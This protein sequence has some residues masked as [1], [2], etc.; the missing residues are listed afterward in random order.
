MPDLYSMYG[1]RG[2]ETRTCWLGGVALVTLLGCRRGVE[3]PALV[4]TGHVGDTGQA[5]PLLAT[6]DCLGD[7]MAVVCYRDADGDGFAPEDATAQ[8][9]C[10]TCPNGYSQRV[11]AEYADCDDENPA[12]YPGATEIC[13]DGVNA[14]CDEDSSDDEAGLTTWF[15]DCD[16]DG[17]GNPGRSEGADCDGP[18]GEPTCGDVELC[19]DG[20]AGWVANNQDTDDRGR[21]CGSLLEIDQDGDG[22]SPSQGDC[23]DDDDSLDPDLYTHGDDDLMI[24]VS[25]GGA[26]TSDPC[27]DLD[28]GMSCPTLDAAIAAAPDD[29][30]AIICLERGTYSL[31]DTL[32]LGTKE[33]VLAGQGSGLTTLLETGQVRVVT[34]AG[35]Q[36]SSTLLYGLTISG[37]AVQDGAGVYVEDSSPTLWRLTVKG[38][39]SEDKPVEKGGGLALIDSEAIVRD[40]QISSNWA[41]RGG[42]M[43]LADGT[44]SPAFDDVTVQG[45]NATDGGGVY[46]D[47]DGGSWS[48][49][50]LSVVSNRAGGSGGGLYILDATVSASAM[51]LSENVAVDDGG[52]L[53]MDDGAFN[54]TAGTS[55]SYIEQNSA[56]GHGGGLCAT[57]AELELSDALVQ[58]NTASQGAGLYATYGSLGLSGVRLIENAAT[59]DGGG[60]WLGHT[61]T[62]L[63]EVSIESNTSG[64][65]GGG[66]YFDGSGVSLIWRRTPISILVDGL[67]VG[68]L[69]RASGAF[70]TS[71]YRATTLTRSSPPPEADAAD[72]LL[73]GG[74]SVELIPH[75]CPWCYVIR[76]NSGLSATDSTFSANS[77]DDRGGALYAAGGQVVF[78]GNST[79]EENAASNGGALALTGST[80]ATGVLTTYKNTASASGGA[81]YLGEDAD[82]DISG[83]CFD[84]N[85]AGSGNGNVLATETNSYAMDNSDFYYGSSDVDRYDHVVYVVP[86]HGTLDV[87]DIKGSTRASCGS[88]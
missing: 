12:I 69:E 57:G 4:E 36:E 66:I 55:G 44:E 64:D 1:S 58:G 87:D 11:S 15:A 65:D 17:L 3:Q 23:W 14:D 27:N 40:V 50:G 54:V 81:L 59:D 68:K 41:L 74:L 73:V 7:D 31:T 24:F 77:A 43:Y 80:T 18:D 46:L 84:K 47:G 83:S 72:R 5:T 35:G 79:L 62:T 25:A 56:G 86:T 38:N 8:T 29:G 22:F 75:R 71:A 85:S 10:A 82:L 30:R 52:G 13:G 42:G 37:G 45:N 49:D 63:L 6:R 20:T 88:R 67:D 16:G 51:T 34:I 48:L 9:S 60:A 39:G 19:E 76:L 26:A 70:E 61:N 78:D 32:D 28:F 2:T 53:Y 21:G 33:I